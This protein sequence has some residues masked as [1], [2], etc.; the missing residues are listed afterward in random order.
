MKSEGAN[1]NVVIYL[2]FMENDLYYSLEQDG[3]YEVL[4][5]T[6]ITGVDPGNTVQWQCADDS[7]QQITSIEVNQS[8]PG[9][10]RNWQDLWLELPVKVDPAGKIFQAVVKPDAPGT[11]QFNGYTIH[12]TTAEGEMEKDPIIKNPKQP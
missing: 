4:T 3:T 1:P 10:D 8:K 9:S 5:E 6:T 7:I 11:Q 2:K 12:Y